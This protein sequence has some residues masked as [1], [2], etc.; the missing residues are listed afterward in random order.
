MRIPVSIL[1]VIFSCINLSAQKTTVQKKIADVPK[2]VVEKKDAGRYEI[3]VFPVAILRL[4]TYTGQT[5]Y[6]VFEQ[7][8]S[9]DSKKWILAEIVGK[10]LPDE[11]SS[12]KP[13][14]RIVMKEI[15]QKYGTPEYHYYL[16]NTETGQ[17]WISKSTFQWSI[18]WEPFSDN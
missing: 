6:T 1:I 5:Y 10:G 17:T 7:T 14:Y 9:D 15:P 8:P 3:L 11:S 13:K 12:N 18:R 4:N 2:S 16:M